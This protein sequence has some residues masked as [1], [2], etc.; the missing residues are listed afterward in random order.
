ML[1]R[2]TINSSTLSRFAHLQMRKGA[3]QDLD[4]QQP[5]L[6]LHVGSHTDPGIR[7]KDRPNE[8]SIFVTQG[9]MPA[10]SASL[11]SFALLVV[12]DGM[13]G[14][15]HGQEA[16]QLA[17][18]SLLEYVADPLKSPQV[19]S[20]D[21]RTLLRAGILHANRAV[22]ERNQEQG[23]IM[24]TTMTVALVIDAI[25]YVAHV[26][27]SRC[28]RYHLPTRLLQITQDH[29]VVAALVT[30]GVIHP[31]DIYTHPRRNL[32]YRCV[33]EKPRVEVDC[34]TVPLVAGDML[35]LCSD[36]LWEMVRDKQIET[37]LTTPS[38]TPSE[39]AQALV[40]AA[41]E[42]GGEDNVSVIVARVSKA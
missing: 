33:G 3:D 2:H 35:L 20:E 30:A 15:G 34:S 36:G 39:T 11:K 8:D 40:Q 22:Y 32:I 24:G 10:A 37:I 26:G 14:Q 12:A 21:I 38:P 29:S 7:R 19:Q 1:L 18:H 6:V 27:D 16:S 28:Y 41:L 31:E 13:G 9:V 42:G 4:T 17:L 23:T 5:A 25:A